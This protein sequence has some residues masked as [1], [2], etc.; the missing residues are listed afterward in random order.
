M[1]LNKA[2]IV[3]VLFCLYLGYLAEE[4]HSCLRPCTV[5]GE[6]LTCYYNWTLAL[7]RTMSKACYDCPKNLSDCYLEDCIAADGTEKM[8]F[9]VN[10]LLPGPKIEICEG[11]TIIVDVKNIL[12]AI[13]TTIH[14]HGIPQRETPYM[15]GTP[16]IT[17]CLIEPYTTFRYK[18]QPKVAG[19][20][21]WHSHAACQRDGIYGALIIRQ[22]KEK[23]R[24]GYLYDY[25]ESSHVIAVQDWFNRTCY[26]KINYVEYSTGAITDHTLLVNG[27]GRFRKINGTYTPVSRFVVKKGYR[28]RFRVINNGLLDCPIAV[29]VD[30]HIV[31]L[32]SSDSRDFKPV[33]ASSFVTYAGERWDF[34][35]NADQPVGLYWIKFK[36]LLFCSQLKSYQVAVLQYEGASDTDI[37]SDKVGYSNAQ[38]KGL[39]VNSLDKVPGSKNSITLPELQSLE[40][41]DPSL[42]K[43]ADV[44]I[45]IVDD[46]YKKNNS[47]YQIA[48][49]FGY[50]QVRPDERNISPQLNNI[51]FIFP[52]I[53]LLPERNRI[54][55]SMFCNESMVTGWDCKSKYC[56]CIHRFKVPLNATVELV[57]VDQG[58]YD[59]NENHPFH[60]HGHFFRTVGMGRIG[61]NNT[62]EKV[63][64]L[65]AEGKV[66][67]NLKNAPLKDT[68]PNIGG[69]YVVLRFFADNP[70]FW[71]F[72]CHVEIHQEEGMAAVFQ[73]GEHDQMLPVPP[74]FPT[75]G[76]YKPNLPNRVVKNN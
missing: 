26:D 63:K 47:H 38:N 75:C 30:S 55:E 70:G 68:T 58:S 43:D 59:D 48:G 49:L 69:G 19:S 50:Y 65:D 4:P 12:P 42:K 5:D 44:Q 36:G 34:V 11:D 9:S 28:Y 72:H 56:E 61:P 41:W 18:F 40:P 16:M 1:C 21:W 54:N 8:I 60:L 33:N 25:D 46:V 37:P 17:Q 32:I 3:S 62:A 29:S 14:W 53:A 66:N 27:R 39:Q 74:N 20:F 31:T 13:S 45:Y 71:F 51:A 24:Q 22:P 6:P 10:K 23:D 76:N 73:I 2:L 64:K 7:F 35:L 57:I 67:R 52:P 15:D